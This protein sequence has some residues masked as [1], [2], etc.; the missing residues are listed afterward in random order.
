MGITKCGI[1]LDSGDLAY[2]TREARKMLDEAGL[3]GAARSRVSNA[4][5]E[6]HHPRPAPSQGAQIDMF[7][8]G[9]RLI[10][11]QQRA[12]V[13]RRV[14]AGRRRGTGRA[15]VIPEDQDFRERGEDHQPRTIKKLYRFY[16]KDTGK[17]IADY[18][19]VYD[20]V[21]DDSKD[22]TIFDPDATWKTK[23]V[24][25]FTARELQ[26]PV[27]KSGELV[28]KLPSA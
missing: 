14:Q 9:E 18:L 10:T 15:T 22:M 11:A 1:R 4:L 21:V 26:V 3:D 28:Y 23:K 2:L 25:N 13:R 12:G 19:T 7:G 16:A 24:Y 8:V 6:Y 17:A 27:F 5:D 20:E